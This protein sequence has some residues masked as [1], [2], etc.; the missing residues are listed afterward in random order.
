MSLLLDLEICNSRHYRRKYLHGVLFS[1]TK[2]RSV[3]L[4][5]WCAHFVD[6]CDTFAFSWVIY[7]ISKMHNFYF[8]SPNSSV[9]IIDRV[10]IRWRPVHKSFK[11]F[12]KENFES[13]WILIRYLVYKSF[14][15]FRLPENGAIG[16]NIV[17]KNHTK[18]HTEKI[19]KN[20]EHFFSELVHFFENYMCITATWQQKVT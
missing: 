18:N 20:P 9:H 2:I 3:H 4:D 11:V 6:L 17:P 12:E 10:A 14:Q 13:V 1:L 16:Y 7:L 5:F 8:Q 19:P 15:I